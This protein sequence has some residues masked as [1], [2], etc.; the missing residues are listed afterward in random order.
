[1]LLCFYPTVFLLLSDADSP[2]NEQSPTFGNEQPMPAYIKSPQQLP[3]NTVH[4]CNNKI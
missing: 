2:V 4:M 3:Y 1:M